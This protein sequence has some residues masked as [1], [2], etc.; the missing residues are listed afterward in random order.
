MKKIDGPA[1]VHAQSLRPTFSL[2]HSPVSYVTVQ[3]HTRQSDFSPIDRPVK[4]PWPRSL[5]P[6]A[7]TQDR[8]MQ[9]GHSSN[10]SDNFFDL[11]DKH[12]FEA[13]I[14]LFCR[15]QA[16]A[17]QCDWLHNY[18]QTDCLQQLFFAREATQRK[19]I[20]RFFYFTGSC[21]AKNMYIFVLVS[22]L[23]PNQFRTDD[24]FFMSHHRILDFVSHIIWV[25]IEWRVVSYWDI[26]IVTAASQ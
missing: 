17:Y 2:L 24:S 25:I 11:L 15:R 6:P 9:T 13:F 16:T 18:L 21:F 12:L 23:V 26:L 14:S 4:P 5:W 10:W 20:I 19:Y 22:K 3:F 8:P 7:L 1:K